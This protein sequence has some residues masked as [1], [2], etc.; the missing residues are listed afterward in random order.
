MLNGR[1]STEKIVIKVWPN[2]STIRDDLS[3][4]LTSEVD[5]DLAYP[6]SILL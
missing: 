4:N 3:L 5:F 2:V 6:G 1:P